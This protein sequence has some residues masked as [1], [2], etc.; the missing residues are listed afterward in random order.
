MEYRHIVGISNS[1]LVLMV[2]ASI[3]FAAMEEEEIAG[4]GWIEVR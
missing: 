1:L 4:I 3:A 2:F